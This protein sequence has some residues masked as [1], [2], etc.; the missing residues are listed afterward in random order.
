[1][2]IYTRFI[3]P[4]MPAGNVRNVPAYVAPI[5]EKTKRKGELPLRVVP[6]TPK[7]AGVR[8]PVLS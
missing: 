8:L 6:I 1:M 2:I 5:V 4:A 7:E 3:R